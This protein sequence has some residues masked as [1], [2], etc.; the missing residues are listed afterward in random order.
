MLLRVSSAAIKSTSRRVLSTRR[1]MSSRFPMGVA[2]KYSFPF[3]FIFSSFLADRGS[4][5]HL[6]VGSCFA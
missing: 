5:F 2:H 3:C 4:F 6:A 1:V